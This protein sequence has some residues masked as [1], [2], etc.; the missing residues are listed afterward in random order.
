[1]AVDAFLYF[2][3]KDPKFQPAGETQDLTYRKYL[4]FE[5]KD[6]SFGIENPTTIGSATMGAGGGKAKFNE[7]TVKKNTDSASALFFR[8]CCSG[9]HY[10][11][12]V[13]AVRKAG[14]AMEGDDSVAG[15]PYLFFA[16]GTVFTT[17]VEWSGPGDEGPE[18]SITFVFGQFGIRY[19]PQDDDGALDEGKK[20]D[21]GWDQQKNIKWADVTTVVTGPVPTPPPGYTVPTST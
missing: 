19:I 6:F 7:F 18:E 4:A 20:S 9:M 5:I 15:K 16:F 2:Y 12:A 10:K 11:N 14:G 13:I 1:M 21:V 8:N 17:K 3:A